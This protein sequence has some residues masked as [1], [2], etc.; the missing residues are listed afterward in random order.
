MKSH[1]FYESV[2]TNWSSS[3]KNGKVHGTRNIVTIK[4]NKGTKTKV[5]MNK[6][7]KVVEKKTIK[8]NK[9]EINNIVNGKF[10][11]GLWNNCTL[12]SCRRS[13]MRNM[14]RRNIRA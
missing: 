6:S 8:L 4:N 5:S 9:K 7:G 14:T 13:R 10:V 2:T 11:P 3:P 12:K 1:I